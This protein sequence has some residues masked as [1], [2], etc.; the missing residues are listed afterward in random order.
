MKK[1][2]INC[3]LQ[4]KLF[5]VVILHFSLVKAAMNASQLCK[6]GSLYYRHCPWFNGVNQTPPFLHFPIAKGGTKTIAHLPI[7]E[8]LSF[9]SLERRIYNCKLRNEIKDL[10][11]VRS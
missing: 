1:F 4:N 11:Q 9:R 6:L 3:Q 10:I 5:L 7:A 2:S 8:G